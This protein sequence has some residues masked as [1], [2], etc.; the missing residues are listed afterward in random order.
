M[1]CCV[2]VRGTVG[3]EAACFGV[4]VL[5]AGTGRFDR[6]GFTLDSASKQEYIEK[7]AGAELLPLP[8]D[9][10]TELARRY[11]YGFLL[12]RPVRLSAIHM[13]FRQTA[14]ADLE[15]SF[16]VNSPKQLCASQDLRAMADWIASGRED[17][18]QPSSLPE[19]ARESRAS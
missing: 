9:K 19:V 12:A 2:T 18:V 15:V 1:D 5:T 11:A 7:L 14:G 6:L 8:T 10:Q 3:I 16:Q 17:Y 4:P 13:R